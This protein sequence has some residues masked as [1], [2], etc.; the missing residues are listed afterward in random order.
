MENC[1]ERGGDIAYKECEVAEAAF[2]DNR[3]RVLEQVIVTENL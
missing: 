2:V 1:C 3:S